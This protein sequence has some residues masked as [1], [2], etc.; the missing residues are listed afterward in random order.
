M[1]CGSQARKSLSYNRDPTLIRRRYKKDTNAIDAPLV[2]C[3]MLCSAVLCCAVL[4]YAMLCCVTT[5][6]L[7]SPL[8]C[9]RLVT[10]PRLPKQTRPCAK[11]SR[12][13]LTAQH[14][15]HALPF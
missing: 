8:V 15:M 13:V 9:G 2:L 14:I 5:A 4:C 7:T 11:A 10:P 1:V 6:K 12:S 3:D